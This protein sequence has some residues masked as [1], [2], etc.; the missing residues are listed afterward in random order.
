MI[1]TVAFLHITKNKC[2]YLSSFAVFKNSLL[3]TFL[4]NI[5][6]RLP[7]ICRLLRLWVKWAKFC[8]F[9]ALKNSRRWSVSWWDKC[10]ALAIA[11]RVWSR[12]DPGIHC[13][14]G[15]WILLSI[16]SESGFKIVLKFFIVFCRQYLPD[17]KNPQGLAKQA[18]VAFCF[19]P[20]A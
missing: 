4:V 14:D 1:P 15:K 3:Y 12:P 7:Q 5:S 9:T 17:S 11:C 2:K 10:L 6:D 20:G 19:M 13:A 16:A 18:D 8:N